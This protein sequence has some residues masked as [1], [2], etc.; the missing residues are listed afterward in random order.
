MAVSK[1]SEESEEQK[2]S[3]GE[4][5]KNEET[6]KVET[7][8]EKD[9]ITLSMADLDELIDS[10]IKSRVSDGGSAELIE[11]LVK[12]LNK[13]NPDNNKK[14]TK[15][16]YRDPEPGD[17]LEEP[18]VFWAQGFQY[19]IGDDVD[20]SGRPIPA[21]LGVID[22]RAISSQKRQNGKEQNI[23][24]TSKHVC[25]SKK[26]L[27]FLRNHSFYGIRFFENV[28]DIDS[29]DIKY[30]ALIAK[31]SQGLRNMDA[32]RVFQQA[33]D[34]KIGITTDD[35][36]T[37]RLMLAQ[38]HAKNEIEKSEEALKVSIRKEKK[39]ALLAG[40]GAKP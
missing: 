40:H 5:N 2:N 31:Y 34:L 20:K 30:A 12:A 36:D 3:A 1:S 35:P 18:V 13:V 14:F 9:L 27:E 11:T 33:R 19:V 38:Y 4:Q 28:R 15:T 32:V 23:L 37:M 8:K 26:E 29:V 7:P 17:L 22:F 25:Q 16:E 24:I 6:P 10:R 39:E 21:P